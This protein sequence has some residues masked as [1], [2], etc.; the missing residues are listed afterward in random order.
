M[1]DR[2]RNAARNGD[3]PSPDAF[4]AMSKEELDH[5]AQ[6]Q[7]QG[8]RN[9]WMVQPVEDAPKPPP[10]LWTRFKRWLSSLTD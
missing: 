9:A 7:A 5:R 4:R 6:W 3:Y 2:Y 10:S 8:A 1:D